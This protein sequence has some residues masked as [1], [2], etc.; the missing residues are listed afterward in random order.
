MLYE[1]ELTPGLVLNHLSG[2]KLLIQILKRRGRAPFFCSLKSFSPGHT[3]LG[4]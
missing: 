4:L 1:F 2:E 3:P